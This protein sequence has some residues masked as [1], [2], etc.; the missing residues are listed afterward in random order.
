MKPR[1]PTLRFA[2]N[3]FFPTA[4]T[5]AGV[6][7]IASHSAH[8]AAGT[9]TG[10]AAGP[11]NWSDTTQWSSGTVADGVGSNAAFNVSGTSPISTVV[12]ATLD[13]ARTIGGISRGG[14]GTGTQARWTITSATKVLTLDNGANN[15]N[16]T[17]GANANTI[18]TVDAEIVL[19]SNLLLSLNGNNNNQIVLGS[20]V[21]GHTITGAKNVTI[22]NSNSFGAG[23]ATINANINTSGSITN[24]SSFGQVHLLAGIIGNTVTGLT[25]S[26]TVGLTLTAA[27]TYAGPTSVSAGT[28]TVNGAN[29]SINQSSGI[30]L[31]G[32]LL[33][34]DNSGTNNTDRIANDVTVSLG[35]ELSL[36]GNAT[37]NPSESFG[38]LTFGLG[39]AALT[40]TSFTGQTA[41]LSASLLARTASAFGTGFVRGSSLG[42]AG[43]S[44]I[45]KI[46]LGATPSGANLVG[47]G[48]APAGST[49]T[50]NLG[51]VPW[52]VGAS[53]VASTAGTGFVT[54][55]TTS[56]SLRPL[57]SG[58]YE[59]NTLTLATAGSNVRDTTASETGI[60]STTLNSLLLVPA[61][62]QTIT[63][64]G[65][66]SNVLTITSGSLASALASGVIG[67]AAFNS[68]ISGFDSVAFGNDEAVITVAQTGGSITINSPVSVTNG[69]GLTKSGVGTLTLGAVNSYT[70]LTI[71]NQG[72]LQVGTAT[73]GDL[74]SN[75]ANIVLNGGTLA[76][77]RTNAGL[78]LSNNISGSGGVIQSGAGGTTVIS[79]TNTY[80]GATAVSAGTLSLTGSLSGTAITTS[81][82]GVVNESSTGV[83]GG[84][85]RFTQGSTGTSIL[86]GVNTYSVGTTVSAGALVIPTGGSL[87]ASSA[88]MNVGGASGAVLAVTGGT[89]GAIGGALRVASASS[90]LLTS[91]GTLYLSGGSITSLQ[92]ATLAWTSTT[93]ATSSTGTFYQTGGAYTQSGGDFYVSAWTSGSATGTV[94]ISGGTFTSFNTKAF[95]LGNNVGGCN[96]VVNVDGTGALTVPSSFSTTNATSAT[97]NLGGGTLTTPAWASAGT[98][99]TTLNFHGGTLKASAAN[100]NFLG[101]GTNAVNLFA[102][103]GTI[104]T[105]ANSLT[106][107]QVLQNPAN[108]G[109]ST[110]AITTP[111]TITVFTSPPTV[112]FTGGTG[113]GGSAYATLDTSGKITGIVVT[114][115]GSYTVA[116]TLSVAG[117]TTVFATPT[118]T[119]NST[120]GLTKNGNGALTLSGANIFTG[121]TAVNAGAL[122]LTNATALTTSSGVTIAGGAALQMLAV[123]PTFSTT[124][125]ALNGTGPGSG[126]ALQTAGGSGTTNWN[127]AVSLGSDSLIAVNGGTRLNIGGTINLGNFNLT[128]QTDGT[129]INTFSGIISGVGG[130]TKTSGSKLV[131]SGANTYTGATNVNG[132]TLALGVAS[133][134]SSTAVSIGSATLDAATFVNTAGTLDAAGV[135]VINL[136]AGGTL[137]FADSSAISWTGG[138]LTLTG[139]YVSGS[140]LRFGTTSGGLTPAQLALISKPGGGAVALNASGYLIDAVAGGYAG[141]QTANS[142]AQAINLDH[143][144]DGVSNGVE[145]FL[146]GNANTT[147]FT[148]LPGVTNTGGILSITWTKAAGYTGTYGNDF[149]VETSSTLTG[150]WGTASLGAGANEVVITGNNVKYTFPASGSPNFA[151]L[152]VTGP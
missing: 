94:S 34:L 38:V 118:L 33:F 134:L 133:A 47:A 30:T 72:T 7:L 82:S 31:N 105:Q 22:A 112:T 136:G 106:I 80:T 68:T 57:A 124:T 98:A 56:G 92:D 95:F 67:T 148:A 78:T 49:T 71:V 137:A 45:G 93:G 143:D 142:T 130:I 117:S 147:G 51:I 61:A 140:S 10:T 141:W 58:E 125:L 110:P 128:V 87:A 146:G 40:A 79:G 108:S 109:I 97:I 21:G 14:T 65:G 74:G 135:S 122:T 115:V 113:S 132:G 48:G 59:T 2:R 99:N 6:A 66:G 44:F 27:N 114:H 104:D 75:T 53:A 1:N 54:Y 150:T 8:A 102:G 18:L 107:T 138:T 100:T 60:A 103:G 25:Q 131:L 5:L 32:G 96:G 144:S 50:T 126:G 37:A 41:T 15:V 116:P 119:A 151:R 17:I 69:G 52:M 85:V 121:P 13:T 55:D 64:A 24:T 63:G 101:A 129:N 88:A 86:S 23:K 16:I 120:G 81:G 26:G 19:N 139:T 11:F 29:G 42:G 111:D 83:I 28:L 89:V 73:T 39:N 70:G 152:R 3:P 12:T 145:Y 62:A 43:S 149:V 91:S 123:S 77:G 35:G 36:T 127:G 84:A 90:T 76:F 46:A 4:M 9:W 20:T